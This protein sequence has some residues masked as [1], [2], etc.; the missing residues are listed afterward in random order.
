MNMGQLW[1]SIWPPLVAV[2][3]FLTVWQAS[4]MIFGIDKWML[5]SPV[6]ISLEAAA[7]TA[8]LWDHTLA[9][10]RLI[11]LGFVIGTLVGLIVAFVL[12]NVPILKSSLYPLVILSQNIPTIALAPLLMVWFGFGILPKII[13]IT[14]VCFF[15]VAVA[16][17]DGLRG[18]DRSMLNYMQMIGAS[19]IDIFRKL[20]LPSA[21][22]SILSGVKIAAT[23]S[24][25]GAVIAEWIGA[26]KG[27]GYYMML[28]KSSFRTDRIFVAIAII[29]LLSLGMFLCIS[30]LEKWIVR[31]KPD[32]RK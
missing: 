16:A 14:L 22:P 27:I 20:E 15:P 12:H 6:D 2:I 30:L 32:N 5:P 23:Y 1:K 31:Y 24:V 10:L 21:I 28:Q 11:L 13:V 3:L 8:G 25:M 4:T 7:N 29:V 18:T 17:M 26:D 9:T 19:K